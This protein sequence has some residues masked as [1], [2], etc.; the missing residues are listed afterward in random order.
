MNSAPVMPQPQ[1]LIVTIFGLYCRGDVEGIAIADLIT[2]LE[3]CGVASSAVRSAV[4]RMKKRGNLTSSR[5]DGITTYAPS[6]HLEEIFQEGDERIFNP[7]RADADDP[8]L[9]AAFSVPESQRHLRHRIRSIFT[10]WGAGTVVPGVWITPLLH[11]PRIREELEHEGLLDLVDFFQAQLWEGADLKDRIPL[12]WDLPAL[13]ARYEEFTRAW[14]PMAESVEDL[15]L[16][17][18]F[19]LYV[20]LLTQWRQL[21]YHDPGL[22]LE[23]LPQPWPA[24]GAMELM[25][26]LERALAPGAGQRFTEVVGAAQVS[27]EASLAATR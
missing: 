4:S 19:R 24:Q 11:A 13:A 20:A 15:P 8:W 10:K 26:R 21:P 17:E 25:Q 5:S 3:D 18:A 7:R 12:W 22:P 14:Q 27:G 23:Y 9:L 6:R 16:P 1:Q 2:L